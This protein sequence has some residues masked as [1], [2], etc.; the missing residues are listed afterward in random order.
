[1]ASSE[2]R[3]SKVARERP[4]CCQECGSERVIFEFC[5]KPSA[6]QQQAIEPYK[7]FIR[8]AY[9]WGC[10]PPNPDSL[11]ALEAWACRQCGESWGA[12]M[13]PQQPFR[14]PSRKYDVP[15]CFATKDELKRRETTQKSTGSLRAKKL[16]RSSTTRELTSCGQR[17]RAKKKF[18]T[19]PNCCALVRT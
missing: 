14:I 9:N 3:V 10:C 18:G 19:L 13:Q 6:E 8:F 15:A 2:Q 11:R 16:D 17:P 5:F 4:V 1:M 7:D 12:V